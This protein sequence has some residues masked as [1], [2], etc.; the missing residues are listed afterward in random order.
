MLR[1]QQLIFPRMIR[2]MS[3]YP[4]SPSQA[5]RAEIAIAAARLIVEEG[6]DYGSAKRR[7]ARDILGN[8]K[9][10]SDI[11]PDN[12][13]IE[14]EVRAHLALFFS[15]TQPKRL[16]HLR[17]LALELMTMLTAFSPYLTGAVLN[18]TA[19]EHSDIHLQL[20]AESSKDVSVFLMDH[21]IQYDVSDS[22]HF[23]RPGDTVETFSFLWH[24]EGIHL[25]VYDSNDVRGALKPN[26]NG[27][28][29]RLDIGGLQ[30]L[31]T[32]QSST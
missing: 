10:R 28:S 17:Q 3:E 15:E 22:A 25:T 5:L 11:L 16:L 4:L 32:A 13:Q 6:A 12:T 1:L 9:P 19:S 18:G 30:A 31:L 8:Q 20:F 2:S 23:K 26:S 14:D 29:D 27:K 24:H 7:A 21:R